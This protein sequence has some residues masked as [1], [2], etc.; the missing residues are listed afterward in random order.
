[1]IKRYFF[2]SHVY[3]IAIISDKYHHLA[4]ANIL[5][6]DS[7][8]GVGFSYSNT[9]SDLLNNG[10]RRTGNTSVLPFASCGSALKFGSMA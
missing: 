9:S 1:M 3:V 10:D 6:L 8:V 4:V 5:F 2:L 7:P